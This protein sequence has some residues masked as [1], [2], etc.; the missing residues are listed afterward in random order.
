MSNATNEID[1]ADAAADNNSNF[2]SDDISDVTS[3]SHTLIVS[4]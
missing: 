2:S 4:D 3:H 1:A